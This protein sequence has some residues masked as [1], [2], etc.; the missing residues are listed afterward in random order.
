MKNIMRTI[1]LLFNKSYW[2]YVFSIKETMNAILGTLGLFWL[3]IEPVSFVFPNVGLW[4]RANWVFVFVAGGIWVAIVNRPRTRYVFKL[5]NTDIS[6]ALSIGDMFD[7]AGNMVVPINTSFDTSF[8]KNLISKKSVQGQFTIKC[9]PDPSHLASTIDQLLKLEMPPIP[10]P[11]K[12]MGNKHRYEIGKVLTVSIGGDRYGYLLATGDMNDSGVASS[13]YENIMTSLG[14]LWE[15]LRERGDVEQI[16]MP[17]LGTGRGRIKE[18]RETIIKTIVHSFISATT[19]TKRFVN[20]LNLVIFINDYAEAKINLK[21]ITDFIR[22]KCL[23]YDYEISVRGLGK[24]VVPEK[25]EVTDRC[26]MRYDEMII[27]YIGKV[28]KGYKSEEE[29]WTEYWWHQQDQYLWWMEGLVIENEF[30]E[31]MIF[32]SISFT[33]DSIVGGINDTLRI[34]KYSDAYL[35]ICQRDVLKSNFTDFIDNVIRKIKI[36]GEQYRIRSVPAM[37]NVETL[38]D[39]IRKYKTNR[40]E[41]V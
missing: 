18:S 21:E 28:Q 20:C 40:N 3:L 22:L 19:A 13:T 25:R 1:G 27:S 7:E 5:K 4:V 35:Y 16:N 24:E 12:T 29:Y 17:L 38:I 6:I 31:W 26:K 30:E 8:E 34:R 2:K 9:F 11:T 33:D 37:K 15:H 41:K 23:Y 39:E 14:S 36:S 32:R 10:A